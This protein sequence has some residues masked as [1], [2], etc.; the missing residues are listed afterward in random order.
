MYTAPVLGIVVCKE[1]LPREE[2][3]GGLVVKGPTLSLLWLDF[4]GPRTSA[5]CRSG[6]NNIVK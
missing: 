5:C 4:P 6:E 3:P 1:I 2:F